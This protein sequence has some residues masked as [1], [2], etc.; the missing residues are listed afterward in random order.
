MISKVD[1]ENQSIVHV[2]TISVRR[3][4]LLGAVHAGR[5]VLHGQV[6]SHHV[7]PHDLLL[8]A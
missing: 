6:L 4:A 1:V 2:P 5:G 8:L 3:G 7:V